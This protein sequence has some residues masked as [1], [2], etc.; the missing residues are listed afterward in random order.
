MPSSAWIRGRGINNEDFLAGI[1]FE[2]VPAIVDL[3]VS[4]ML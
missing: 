3:T 1:R 4:I 2:T